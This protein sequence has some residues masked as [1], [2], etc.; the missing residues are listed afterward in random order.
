MKTMNLL[1]AAVVSAGL[2]FGI[3]AQAGE[4]WSRGIDL[5]TLPAAVQKTI[6][7][8]AAGGKI[9]RVRREDDRDG[10]WN[11]EVVVKTDGKEWGF[12]VDPNGKFVKKH[13]VHAKTESERI[14][15][16]ATTD[17]FWSIVASEP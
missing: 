6:T 5:K 2:M 11:Y 13:P 8:T 3:T 17:M 1:L 15:T 4:Y 16:K 14:N 9:I 10:K 7:E 12:E